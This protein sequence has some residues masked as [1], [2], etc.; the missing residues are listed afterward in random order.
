MKINNIQGE[1][2]DISAKKE[3]LVSAAGRYW[4]YAAQLFPPDLFYKALFRPAFKLL[5]DKMELK[6]L[7]LELSK[8]SIP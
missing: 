1:L 8:E 3:A 7:E 5:R 2:T 6:K 4:V